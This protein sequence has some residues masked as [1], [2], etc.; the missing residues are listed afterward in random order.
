MRGARFFGFYARWRSL[1]VPNYNWN[2]L[3]GKIYFAGV[4]DSAGTRPLCQESLRVRRMLTQIVPGEAEA[5]GLVALMEFQSSRFKPRMNT[6]GEPILLL[7]QN[8][9]MWDY[10]L[11]RRGT[12]A[13]ERARKRG[14]PLGAYALQASIAACHAQA[15]E[16]EHEPERAFREGELPSAR[17]REAG[18]LLASCMPRYGANAMGQ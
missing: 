6:A 8:R 4:V 5:H 16:P 11:I 10:L 17:V 12:A 13:L 2:I 14:Y 3:C 18:L 1:S 7:D 9:G 15:L